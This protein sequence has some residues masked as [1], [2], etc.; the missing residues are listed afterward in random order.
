M[1][2]IYHTDLTKKLFAFKLRFVF[3]LLACFVGALDGK[4]AS[5]YVPFLEYPYSLSEFSMTKLREALLVL[6]Q[7]EWMS[8]D[9]Y[10]KILTASG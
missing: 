4:V 10:A 8:H 2:L 9:E 6:F 1:I 7:E 3:T 5:S